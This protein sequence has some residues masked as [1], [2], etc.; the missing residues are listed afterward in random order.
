MRLPG[1]A[2]RQ[3][4]ALLLAVMPEQQEVVPAWVPAA[5]PQAMAA[6]ARSTASGAL[7]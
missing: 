4:L 5:A 1:L 6:A 7:R 3:E 2:V